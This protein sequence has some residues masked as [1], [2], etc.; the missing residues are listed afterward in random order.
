MDKCWLS[1]E[2]QIALLK[3]RGM[4]IDNESRALSYIEKIG[5]YR[6]SGYWYP[7]RKIIRKDKVL[8]PSNKK[9]H[10]L[11]DIGSD[12]FIE[13]VHFKQIVELYVFDKKLKMLCMDAIER[14]E[15]SPRARISY[16][17]GN[18]SPYSYLEPGRFLSKSVV[19]HQKWVQKH[20][21]LIKRSKERFIEHNRKN[22][23]L[24]LFVWV[25]CEIWDF[26]SLS[27]LY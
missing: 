2:D 8:K 19:E 12:N 4:H 22:Y 24:P 11:K 3:K 23:G 16:H 15:I 7:F 13:D 26:G 17:L 25:A 14:I 21:V 20:E 18:K 10:Y 9:S 6:L 27:K 1:L 5:Y